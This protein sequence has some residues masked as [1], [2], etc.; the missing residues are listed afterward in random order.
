MNNQLKENDI[1]EPIVWLY[2]KKIKLRAQVGKGI[3][4]VQFVVY[5]GK[6]VYIFVIFTT[7]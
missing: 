2:V 7:N 6:N 5:K 3:G 1:Y 4:I